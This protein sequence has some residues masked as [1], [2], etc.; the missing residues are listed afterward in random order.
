M[1]VNN[2]KY[3]VIARNEVTKQSFTMLTVVILLFFGMITLAH[4]DIYIN[5][6]AVNGASEKKLR[7]SN[8]TFLAKFLQKISWMPAACKLTIM[9]MMQIILCTEM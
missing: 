2:Y 3:S 4:A 9:S 5:V 6:V 8:L 7:R 1:K